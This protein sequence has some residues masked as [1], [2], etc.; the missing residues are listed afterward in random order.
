[1]RFAAPIAFVLCIISATLGLAQTPIKVK[2]NLVGV[3]FTARDAKGA[4]VDN[5]TKDD[6]EVFEDGV[7]QEISY[8]ARS[9]DA[10][11]T[12]GL[13]LDASDSQGHALKNHERDL[14]V[15]LHD[16]LRPQDKVFLVYFGD[17]IRV[18][19]DFGQTVT[20]LLENLKQFQTKSSVF[21]EI[22]PDDTRNDG[23]AFYDAIYYSVSEKLEKENGRR[24]LLMFSDGEDNSSAYDMMTAIETAQAADVRVYTIRYTQIKRG[25]L[26]SRNKYGIRVMDRIARE[27]GGTHV[28]A[29]HT[30]PHIY[31]KQIGEELRSTYELA[32]Y[33]ANPAKDNT[34][35][36]VSIRPKNSE[37]TVRSRTGYFSR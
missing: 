6:V 18:V 25:K 30:D 15:F 10:P 7:K 29:A 28:D 26:T 8:F 3:S 5:L 23:T 13:I 36:K 9:D 34:F 21:P 19:S 31:F 17:H 4:L 35:R 33:P 37:I 1:M 14:E 27:T 22:G 11:L 24:A 16:V 20:E 32:Y 2:V 12:L